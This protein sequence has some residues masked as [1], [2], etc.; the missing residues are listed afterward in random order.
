MAILAWAI[1]T[2]MAENHWKKNQWK[3]TGKLKRY[4][5]HTFGYLMNENIKENLPAG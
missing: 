2:F 1:D 3:T 4:V 5:G